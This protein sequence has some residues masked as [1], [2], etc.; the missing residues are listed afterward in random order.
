MVRSVEKKARPAHIASST[1]TEPTITRTGFLATTSPTRF[2]T[3]CVTSVT[4]SCLKRRSSYG[5][6]IARSSGPKMTDGIL[7]PLSLRSSA[8]RSTSGRSNTTSRHAP[9]TGS[10]AVRREPSTILRARPPFGMCLATAHSRV[11]G[12]NG[13]N[14]RRPK[15]VSSAGSRVSIEMQAQATPIAP[16]GPRPAVPFTFAIDRHRRAAIT[17]AAEA[18]TAGPAEAIAACMASWRSSLRCSSSL[19]LATIRS[20]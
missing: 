15:I 5:L 14:A 2:Q 19:Y 3:P 7:P 16:I 17:V 12:T 6:K 8:F 4:R 10:S 20:A 13:Q 9:I 18:N 11:W 1:A